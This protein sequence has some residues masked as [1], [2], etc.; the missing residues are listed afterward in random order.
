MGKR[1][2]MCCALIKGFIIKFKCGRGPR[3]KT[4]GKIRDQ[5]EIFQLLTNGIHIVI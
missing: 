4:L 2:E 5:A 3:E 1:G